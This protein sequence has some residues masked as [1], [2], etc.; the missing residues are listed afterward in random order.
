MSKKKGSGLGSSFACAN[1]YVGA[2]VGPALVAGTYAVTFFLPAGCNSL[3][4]PFLG[5]GIVGLFCVFAAEII[6]E[7]RTYEYGSAAK[8]IYFNKGI[9]R[10]LFEFYVLL[11]N[12]VGCALVQSMSGTFVKEL[13]GLPDVA[14][15]IIIGVISLVIIYFRDKAIRFLN[16]VMSV[17]ML[18]GFV[19]ISIIVIFMFKDKL[20]SVIGEWYVPEGAT[21]FGSAKLIGTF[22]FA[23][24]A[25]A[26][27]LCCVEQT[28]KTKKQSIWIGIFTMIMGG[29]MMALSCLSFLPITTEIQGDA[30]PLI[31]LMNNYISDSFAWMPAMYYIIMILAIISSVVPGAFMVAS[32]WQTV[33]PSVGILKAKTEEKSGNR[34]CMLVAIIYVI[35]CSVISL[36]G[37]SNVLNYG[38]T[39]VGYIG[40]PLVIIPICFIW[41]F[42]LHKMRK[43]RRVAG[44]PETTA[45]IEE[46]EQA[47]AKQQLQK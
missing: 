4:T 18:V 13:T 35:V 23:S 8:K 5:C 22:A 29:L 14:G 43:E 40:M 25:F 19:V 38:L 2:L 3:W 24:S 33:I 37:V 6:R 27:T 7:Y 17:I 39:I 34:K 42:K 44:L 32:R 46:M 15:M 47:K 1:V 20:F 21:F 16:S 28:I 45:E 31:Y 11:S 26:I 10:G 12:I 41:P 9:L 30:M 36:A